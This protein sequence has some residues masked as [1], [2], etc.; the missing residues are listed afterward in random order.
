MKGTYCPTCETFVETRDE[1]A[2][3]TIPVRGEPIAVAASVRHCAVCNE[4]LVSEDYEA[5]MLE[6]AYGQYRTRHGLLAPREIREIRDKY[7]LSQRSMARLLGWG[8]ITLHRY[9]NGALQDAAHDS[10]LRLISEPSNLKTLVD[11]A[12]DRLPGATLEKLRERLD[13]TLREERLSRL[14]RCVENIAEYSS[15]DEYSGFRTFDI[16]RFFAV[17]LEITRQCGGLVKTKLNKM[18]WYCD[19]LHFRDHAVSITGSP[20]L[21]RPYGPVPQH[22]EMLL[23]LM[24]LE[25]LLTRTEQVFDADKGIVGEV[26]SAGS[27]KGRPVLMASERTAIK[28]VAALFGAWTARRLTEASHHEFAYINAAANQMIS[29][30]YARELAIP[31]PE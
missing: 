18:L 31:R 3:Q 6:R 9:E 12:G 23:C 14:R 26:L 21:H 20:Y 29:Y 16:D 2:E 1:T 17:V 25:G 27:A 15:S 22:Y 11:G 28:T 24:E 19:F 30:K 13:E 5:E 10:L 7:G 8:D 4:A